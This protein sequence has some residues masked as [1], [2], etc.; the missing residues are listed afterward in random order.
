MTSTSPE[1]PPSSESA[2]S[3]LRRDRAPGLS[4][5]K[6]VFG[7]FGFAALI[8]ATL[9]AYW[10]FYTRPFRDVQVAIAD[11]FPGSQPQVIGGKHKSHKSD[12]RA[13]LRIVVRVPSD[14]RV[15][16]AASEGMALRLVGI[17]EK[18]HDLSRYQ[19]VDV[20]LVHRVPESEPQHWNSS[21]PV[22]EW[23]TLLA[24]PGP[25]DAAPAEPALR[26]PS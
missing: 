13:E 7:M 16:V 5:Q 25:K 3:P 1:L 18:H 23:R 12:A 22:A 8:V 9:F 14:P 6:V 17:A 2:A 20:I 10:H 26:N 15:D 11:V 21:R 4:G 19:Q 24:A